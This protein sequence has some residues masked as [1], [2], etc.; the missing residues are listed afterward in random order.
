M[1][2]GGTWSGSARRNYVRWFDS[3]RRIVRLWAAQISVELFTEAEAACAD[4]AGRA[5]HEWKTRPLIAAAVERA[6]EAADRHGGAPGGSLGGADVIVVG[7]TRCA[8]DI[9]SEFCLCRNLRPFE[10]RAAVVKLR[11]S[12]S[13]AATDYCARLRLS[14][15]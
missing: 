10:P 1:S 5:M 6:I 3:A 15:Q 9:N 2:L 8:A 11:V 13:I 4:G 7:N 14:G 12:F